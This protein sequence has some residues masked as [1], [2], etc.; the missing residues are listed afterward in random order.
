MKVSEVMSTQP[1][2]CTSS[3]TVQ[4]VAKMMVEHDCGAIPVVASEESLRPVGVITDRDIATRLVAQ[5][6][7]PLHCTAQDAM[8]PAAVA[9]NAHAGV[10]DAARAMQKYRLRRLLVV[11][12]K[13]DCVGMLSLADIADALPE[14]KSA[15]VLKEISR[16]NARSSAA[17]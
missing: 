13:G 11:S 4:E 17:A 14:A 1:A 7:D 15:V 9:V 5:G 16:P 8:T 6:R 10:D 2:Y 12:G 3:T